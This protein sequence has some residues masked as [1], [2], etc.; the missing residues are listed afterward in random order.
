MVEVV[1]REVLSGFA[2]ILAVALRKEEVLNVIQYQVLITPAGC[3]GEWGVVGVGKL[4][5]CK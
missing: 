4:N 2:V 3:V 1:L 5:N